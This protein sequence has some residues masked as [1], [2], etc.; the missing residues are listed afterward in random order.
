MTVGSECVVG[1]RSVKCLLGVE[2]KVCKKFHYLRR[3]VLEGHIETRRIN[4]KDNFADIFTKALARADVERIL[5]KL[6]MEKTSCMSSSQGPR[7]SVES[8]S[9]DEDKES[10]PSEVC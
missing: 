5:K 7:G 2:T 3:M 1:S 9:F 8:G 6:G 10:L 4:S